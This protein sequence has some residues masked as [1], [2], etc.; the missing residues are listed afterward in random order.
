MFRVFEDYL[1]PACS[2]RTG[3]PSFGG[4]L[5][6]GRFRRSEGRPGARSIGY[7]HV[8]MALQALDA[9]WAVLESEQ[10]VAP[11]ECGNQVSLMRDST[12]F[13]RS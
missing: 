3:A 7:R 10:H 6:R 13:E 2:R 9:D 12:S 4:A 8:D 11:G 1:G 5:T